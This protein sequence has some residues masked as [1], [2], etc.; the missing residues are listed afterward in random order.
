MLLV[1]LVGFPTSWIT[2]CL[3]GAHRER[4]KAILRV[5]NRIILW[6]FGF[7]WVTIKGTI[8]P[9]ARMFVAN[10]MSLVEGVFLSS[11]IGASTVAAMELEKGWLGRIIGPFM[12]ALDT[13]LVNRR[14]PSGAVTAMHA[15]LNNGHKVFAHPEGL[16]LNGDAIGP[17]S[18]GAFVAACMSASATQYKVQAAAVKFRYTHL[19]PS[20]GNIGP[21][22]T[23]LIFRMMCSVWNTMEI[24]F[25]EAHTMANASDNRDANKMAATAFAEDTRIAIQTALGIPLTCYTVGDNAL[26]S[27]A[28]TLHVDPRMAYVQVMRLQ[29]ASALQSDRS[30]Q[31]ARP[32][33]VKQLG[34][35]LEKLLKE[36]V[37]QPGYVATAQAFADFAMPRLATSTAENPTGLVDVMIHL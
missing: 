21:S 32:A 28:K 3:S 10:H 24:E 27:Y 7:W 2:Q 26:G 6:C 33:D 14:E 16:C 23:Q 29:A 34:K 15:S 37:A 12:R 36:Y 25:L 5:L 22:L 20:W 19:D 9:D 17:F 30:G 4:G 18:T 1:I 35:L 13:I 11:Y 31:P 8:D